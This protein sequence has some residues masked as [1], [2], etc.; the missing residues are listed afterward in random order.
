MEH[1]EE[2]LPRELLRR[3]SIRGHE[4][5]WRVSDI[6]EVIEATKRAGRIS[7][8]GQLQF[9]FPNNVTCECYWVEVDTLKAVAADIPRKEL[10]VQS[11]NAAL[12]AFEDLRSH[13]DFVA[14]GRSSFEKVFKEFEATGGEPEEVM[15]FVWY[16]GV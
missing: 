10:V 2:S 5:A 8:G 12:S 11:A 9:R 7:V 15:W 4:Y 14:E 3:A 16:V 13:F 1:P 6:P